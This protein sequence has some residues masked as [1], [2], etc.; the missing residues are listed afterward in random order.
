[1][2]LHQKLKMWLQLVSPMLAN[3][4]EFT[5]A[6]HFVQMDSA[7]A[8]L[9]KKGKIRSVCFLIMLCL[10]NMKHKNNYEFIGL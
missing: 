5:I 8:W 2:L 6:Y 10:R 1:M 4:I 7:F 3:T 9:E